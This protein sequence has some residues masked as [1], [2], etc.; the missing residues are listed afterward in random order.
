MTM[1]RGNPR[2]LRKDRRKQLKNKKSIPAPSNSIT[3]EL[4]AAYQLPIHSDFKRVSTAALIKELQRRPEA[5]ALL[6][7]IA[8]SK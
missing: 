2:R 7:A 3:G 5:S 1:S 4:A 6:S 8:E